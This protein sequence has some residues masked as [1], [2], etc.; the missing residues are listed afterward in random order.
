M[1]ETEYVEFVSL[2][3]ERARAEQRRRLRLIAAVFAR[4]KARAK[5]HVANAADSRRMMYASTRRN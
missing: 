5:L 3:E 2:I 1:N 4:A